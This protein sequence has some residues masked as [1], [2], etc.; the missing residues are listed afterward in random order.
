MPR[1][2]EVPKGQPLRTIW[3]P[4]CNF[5]CLGQSDNRQFRTPTK[6]CN[7]VKL[8]NYAPKRAHAVEGILYLK[9]KMLNKWPLT[10][11]CFRINKSF[12]PFSR[13]TIK[14][15]KQ[16]L[17]FFISL[18]LE[19]TVSTNDRV[20]IVR[21]LQ[22]LMMSWVSLGKCLFMLFHFISCHFI[23]LVSPLLILIHKY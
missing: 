12:I 9:S 22:T 18:S 17:K 23:D 11:C 8:V 6:E 19:V 13:I 20:L 4:Y 14:M 10:S 1:Q 5:G 21:T 2:T 16:V 3:L 7:L 15:G